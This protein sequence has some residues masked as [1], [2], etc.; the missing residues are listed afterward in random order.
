MLSLKILFISVY[1]KLSGNGIQIHLKNKKRK[2]KKT[3]E[4]EVILFENIDKINFGNNL[5]TQE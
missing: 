4:I 2:L 3:S 1:I 5:S